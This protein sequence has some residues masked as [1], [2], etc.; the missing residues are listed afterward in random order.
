M[1]IKDETKAP[2][3]KKDIRI[4]TAQRAEGPYSPASPAFTP[5]WVE[6]P[7]ALKMGEYW[8]VYYDAYTRHCMEGARSKNLKTWE[9]I[10]DQLSFPKGIRHGTALAVPSDILAGLQDVR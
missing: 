4:A 7:T 10:T 3:P 2:V 8:Y 6:G 9:A 5:D 1:F